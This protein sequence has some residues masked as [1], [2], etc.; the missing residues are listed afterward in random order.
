MA[1]ISLLQLLLGTLLAVVVAML[2]FRAKVLSQSG[3]LAASILGIVVF[4]L[5]GIN[6]A[7]LLLAF[8]ISSSALSKV[9][10]R[11]KKSLVEKFS[12]G[13]TR[14]SSQVL[15]NG[16]VAGVF[17]LLH[18][19]FPNEAW[20]WLGFAGALAA[21]NADTWAT[22]LGV[23]SKGDAIHLL[24]RKK[25]ERGTS[26]AI[27]MLGTVAALLGGLL[28][29]FLAIIFWP[30][31]I[32]RWAGDIWWIPLIA[33]SLAGLFG[34][35]VDSILGAGLQAIYYCPTCN[36]ETERSPFHICGSHTTFKRGWVWLNNDWVNASCALAGG[37]L[38]VVL[39]L[40]K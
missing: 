15:A 32:G 20:P 35:M 28:I 25:V 34:S 30:D 23:L 36:K 31:K 37:L 24:S 26:G 2:S 11:R 29:S 40:L 19:F 22:E 16:G 6:W 12:K 14:D 21:V 3:A 17:V 8:F 4:G 18:L 1:Q 7:I 33:I 38:M 27:S 9:A 10:G 39:S 5:G 13:S